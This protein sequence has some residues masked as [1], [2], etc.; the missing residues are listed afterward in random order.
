MK[1]VFI[2]NNGDVLRKVEAALRA[3]RSEV[4]FRQEQEGQAALDSMVE[5]TPD[6]VV[7]HPDFEDMSLRLLL[8][9][10]RA[11]HGNLPLIVIGAHDDEVE[12]VLALDHRADEY[13]K[14]TA[15]LAEFMAWLNHVL[16]DKGIK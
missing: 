1:V 11:S 13:I 4:S 5:D 2:G 9:G 14:S 16:R 12:A 3:G 8:V 10:L 7:I 15:T 6:V